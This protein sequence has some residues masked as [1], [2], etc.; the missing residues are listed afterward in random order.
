MTVLTGAGCLVAIVT[1]LTGAFPSSAAISFAAVWVVA[2]LLLQTLP[3]VLVGLAEED[4]E[5]Y[6]SGAD[7]LEGAG[8]FVDWV[9]PIGFVSGIVLGY[10]LW[11]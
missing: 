8:W 10:W 11:L 4:P 6:L 5:A 2:M 7:E 9:V 1:A 3:R